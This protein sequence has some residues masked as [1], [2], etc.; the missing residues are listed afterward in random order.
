M[1]TIFKRFLYIMPHPVSPP[2]PPSPQFSFHSNGID[3]VKAFGS[4]VNNKTFLVTGP[5]A[6]SIGAET[7]ISLAHGGPSTLFLASRSPA[8]V[9]PVIKQIQ[10]ISPGTRCEFVQLDLGSQKSV[11]AAAEQVKNRLGNGV[12][13][14]VVINNAAVM[15]IEKFEKTEDGV[16]KQFGTNHLGH[17]LLTNLLIPAGVKRVVNVTSTAYESFGD[18]KFSPEDVNFHVWPST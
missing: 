1:S 16:E 15:A 10:K 13:L 4:Q 17:F 12:K 7:A 5:S 6:S 9:A 2:L 14:D 8:K 3:V 11:R 18:G